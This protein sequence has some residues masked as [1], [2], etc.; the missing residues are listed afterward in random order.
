MPLLEQGATRKGWGVWSD[1]GLPACLPAY[2][3]ALVSSCPRVLV[4]SCPWGC[5][6]RDLA[7]RELEARA[8][9]EKNSDHDRHG[10]HHDGDGDDGDHAMDE[11]ESA[12]SR[13]FSYGSSR[14]GNTLSET[15]SSSSSSEDSHR[16]SQEHSAS[17][18]A[19]RRSGDGTCSEGRPRSGSGSGSEASRSSGQVT[20]RPP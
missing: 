12:V 4:S 8:R 20:L 15:D 9:Y 16:V 14:T 1:G 13:S 5:R 7:Q 17:R 18:V 2:P 6:A 3:R 10:G 19:H 11:S